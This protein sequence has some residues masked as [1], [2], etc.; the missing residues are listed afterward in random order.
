M[1]RIQD[2]VAWT[3]GEDDDSAHVSAWNSAFD[4][5]KPGSWKPSDSG[6]LGWT[7]DPASC[8]SSSQPSGGVVQVCSLRIEKSGT[9]S[10]ILMHVQTAGSTLTTGGCWA[11]LADENN[12]LLVT[13]A[14]QKT[15]WQ[16]VGAKDMALLSGLDVEEG[17]ILKGLFVS[18]GTVQPAFSRSVSYSGTVININHGA[19]NYRFATADTGR[20][21]IP[22]SL[23]SQTPT[24][25]PFFMGVK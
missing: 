23:G 14:D 4:L 17:Q 1:A 13:T 19:T 18:N 10:A 8:S 21:T 5:N 15:A 7:I 6:M 16:S 11:G 3:L 12:N 24:G 9:L 20:T 2:G 22:L 25:I